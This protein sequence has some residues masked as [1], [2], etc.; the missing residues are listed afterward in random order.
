MSVVVSLPLRKI[1]SAQLMRKSLENL[2]SR[3]DQQI[4]T[5]KI[6]IS[7]FKSWSSNFSPASLNSTHDLDLQK[8]MKKYQAIPDKYQAE[9]LWNRCFSSHCHY[10]DQKPKTESSMQPPALI[11]HQNCTWPLATSY[12]IKEMMHIPIVFIN[13]N[14]AK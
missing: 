11:H 9:H 7:L 5:F 1:A 14:K 2:N 8:F 10:I 13:H 3:K 12:S 6:L 4:Q